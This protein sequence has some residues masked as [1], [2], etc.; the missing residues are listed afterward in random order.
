[1]QQLLPGAAETARCG[2]CRRHHAVK[3]EGPLAFIFC[4]DGVP[5][6]VAV[7]PTRYD[8]SAPQVTPAQS[9]AYEVERRKVFGR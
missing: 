8:A 5:A 4:G 2:R 1:M 7:R 9:R 3:H 6:I